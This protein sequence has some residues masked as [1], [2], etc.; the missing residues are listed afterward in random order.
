[1][2]LA[3][4]GI[5]RT[6]PAP[7]PG[8]LEHAFAHLLQLPDLSAAPFHQALR[9]VLRHPGSMLRPR[10]AFQLAVARGC[11][12]SLALQLA[13]ALEYFHTASLL[14]DDLPSM[15]DAATR[16]GRPCVHTSHGESA[17]ILAALALV[18][19]AYALAWSAAEAAPPEARR[20]ALLYLERQL[21]LSGLLL[22][23][24][25]DL[26]FHAAPATLAAAERVARGKTVPLIA[27]PIVFPALLFA[28]P[29]RHVQLL[30]RLS[31]CWGLAYQLADDL[32]DV[33]HS[34]AQAGKSTA[35]DAALGRP[36]IALLLGIP[37]AVDRLC[38]WIR[39]GDR[40]LDALDRRQPVEPCLHELRAALKLQLNR[41]LESAGAVP[42]DRKR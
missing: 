32:K 25:L 36:N 37:A 16:R 19:R 15:D 7:A 13:V 27:L 24:S 2:P 35:R 34:S 29:P 33:L 20:P 6:L 18:N 42:I 26:H 17:A 38:R 31:L 41:L 4:L 9:D 12:R 8:E 3:Q 14:L 5:P 21:G 23:Q 22:G 30:Q 11:P 39:A 40:V 28:A 10:I 1:M